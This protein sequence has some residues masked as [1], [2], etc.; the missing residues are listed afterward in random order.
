MVLPTYDAPRLPRQLDKAQSDKVREA[1]LYC[2]APACLVD[3]IQVLMEPNRDLR[4]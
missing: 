1:L 3:E 4:M 2:R